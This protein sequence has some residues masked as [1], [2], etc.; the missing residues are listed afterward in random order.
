MSL[1]MQARVVPAVDSIENGSRIEIE[2]KQDKPR[3]TA[4]TPERTNEM[5]NLA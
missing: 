4:S 3:T 2:D 5:D 1:L